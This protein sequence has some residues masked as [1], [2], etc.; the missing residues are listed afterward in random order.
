MNDVLEIRTLGGLAIKRNGQPVSGFASRKVEA[1][2]VYLA[3]TRRAFPREVLAELL[4]EERSQAQAL[5]NLRVALTSLRQSVGPFITISRQMVGINPDSACWLDV[6]EFQAHLAAAGKTTAAHLEKA[7]NLY[8]GDFLA[9][10]YI[11]SR[12]FEDWVLPERERLRLKVMDA[13]DLLIQSSMNEAD[14]P[15]ALTHATHLLQLDSLREETYRIL[16][17]L[18]ARSG[19]RGAALAQYETCCRVLDEELGIEPTPETTAL[20]EQ[21]RAGEIDLGEPAAPLIHRFRIVEQIKG[22]ETVSIFR[23]VDLHTHQPVVIKTLPAASY[24]IERFQRQAEILRRLNHPNVVRVLAAFEE[25]DWLYIVTEYVSG[26][27]LQELIWRQSPLPVERVIHIALDLADTLARAHR[28]GIVHGNLKPSNVLLTDEGTPRLA[29]FG[30]NSLESIHAYLSP[31][32]LGGEEPDR[33]ADIWALGVLCFEMLAGHPP[34]EGSTP[35]SLQS[36]ILHQAVPD[37]ELLRPDAPVGLVDLIYRMLEKDR[38]ARIPTVR[39]IG[40]ELEALASSEPAQ[41]DSL[42]AALIPIRGVPK[43]NLEAQL[44][45]FVGRARELSELTRLLNDSQTRLITIHGPGGVGKT[46]LA[47]E[48]AAQHAGRFANGVHLIPLAGI[49]TVDTMVAAIADAVNFTFS[50]IGD[51][52]QQLLNYLGKAQDMLLVMDN[53]EDVSNGSWLISQILYAAPAIK[54]LVTSRERLHLS[55][56]EIFR[57][58]GMDIPQWEPLEE[59]VTYDAV[60]LFLQSARRVLPGFELKADDLSPVLHICRRVLGMPL[61]IVLAAAWV[62]VLSPQEIADEIDQ[63]LD[64]LESDIRDMPERHRSIRA[65]FESTWVRLSETER[66]VFMKL[67]IFRG[68]VKRSVAQYVTRASLATL[69]AL[70]NKSLLRRDPDSGRYEVHEL[71][72]QYAE[73]KLEATGQADIARDIHSHYY[74]SLLCQREADLKGHRQIEAIREIQA[75]FENMRAAWTWT[76]RKNDQTMVSLALNSLFLFCSTAGFFE[77]GEELLR[78]ALTQFAPRPGQDPELLWARILVRRELMLDPHPGA[79]E[80]VE[81]G[82]TVAR[83]YGDQA[84][85]AFCLWVLGYAISGM[86]DIAGAIP[87]FEESL[88]M[89]RALNDP[90]QIGR[91]LSDIGLFYG[92]LGQREKSIACFQ[93]ALQ[94]QRD[95][96]D[97][98]GATHLVIRNGINT[99]MGDNLV[100]SYS[101]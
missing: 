40:A 37:L 68:G 83:Q 77:P 5:A 99:R 8:Q 27:S 1:L 12:G 101:G 52:Q 73:E 4:W 49:S 69:T 33:R 36:A 65:V 76:V 59:A 98:V 25:G 46:R 91:V 11:D 43:H 21:I 53:C 88:M 13:L 72:R 57:L 70:V 100:P 41:R 17:L 23:G 31:E 95:N 45:P 28:S 58:G 3:C 16:M 14:Y 63:N 74:M 38:Y 18:L 66:D 42:F 6:T 34:F 90:F 84:E 64:F 10:F 9:G 51:N 61:G 89:Y 78:Q 32:A 50:P 60:K 19:Q 87:L 29:D 22:R 85:V 62:E 54:I 80:Q 20:Y 30:I 44:T 48:C 26:G 94:I 56:E 93:Q 2:L 82:L 97:E 55:A 39:V 96:G 67:A 86:G 47:I 7:L 75:E 24:D 71:L 35:D 15:T 92:V 79:R 81:Y